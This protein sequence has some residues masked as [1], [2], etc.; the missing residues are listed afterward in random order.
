MTRILIVDDMAVFREPIAAALRAKGY[1]TGCAENGRQALAMVKNRAPD[2]ILLDVAMPVMN[3]LDYLKAVRD[4]PSI[5]RPPIILL[6]AV[7]EKDYVV[8][9]A[10]LGVREYMLK[11]SFSLD[12]LL[13][14]IGRCL[15]EARSAS[16]PESG[17]ARP[18]AAPAPPAAPARAPEARPPAG[19]GGV[20]HRLG[21]CHDL[22][23][24]SPAVSLVLEATAGEGSPMDAVAA[25]IRQDQ[26]ITL[27]ILKLANS[28]LYKRGR[29]CDT[30]DKAV[31]RIGSVGIRQAVLN[32]G[33]IDRFSNVK[34]GTLD[35]GQF[36]EHSLACGFIS[37][38]LAAAR[39][40][41]RELAFTAGLLHDVGRVALAQELGGEY[42]AVWRAAAEEG[43]PL[44]HAEARLL[45]IDHAEAMGHLLEKWSFPRDLADPIVL[46]HH[47]PASIRAA[48]PGRV[49]AV[50]TLAL[51]D[52]LC[53][54]LCLGSSGNDTVYPTDELCDLLGVD[55]VL[56]ARI[57]ATARKSTEELQL[58]MLAASWGQGWVDGRQKLRSGL[59]RALY[60]LF[61][62]RNPDRDA[63]RIFSQQLAD[64]RPGALNVG[65]VH[66]ASPREQAPVS[67][68]FEF[69][70]SQ[71]SGLRLP[72]VILSPKGDLG[73]EPRAMAGRH[74]E[75][76][77]TP[78]AA[79]RMIAAINRALGAAAGSAAA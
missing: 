15:E 19:R 13:G 17:P 69:A 5:A 36:W 44:E 65:I 3:G 11:S 24:F 68:R 6:T 37:G 12:D 8:Q 25:A 62:S 33:V 52:R 1:E 73:L 72:L 67:Q 64:P 43:V 49:H 29:P 58:V 32:I 75:F 38:E 35:A 31:M 26:A 54:A 59:D 28:A 47:S 27:R 22:K 9:A 56:L 4:D 57:V 2:L 34:L 70:E 74:C 76:L 53:H 23:A 14:R 39:G 16:A 21:A 30:I 20:L 55:S 10:Q 71:A 66:L 42:E 79:P 78:V 40:A 41:D 61:V 48:A 51:A 7:A 63:Y 50:A 77:A 60:P 18:R 45:G 46:H